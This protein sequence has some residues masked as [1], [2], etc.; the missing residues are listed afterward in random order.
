[1]SRRCDLEPRRATARTAGTTTT[2]IRGRVVSDDTGDPI[3]NARVGIADGPDAPAALTDAEGRFI[4]PVP[5]GQ[6]DLSASK[7]GYV[8]ATAPP[9]DGAEI[10]LVKGAASIGRVLDDLGEPMPVMNVVAFRRGLT[11]GHATFDRVSAAETDDLGEYRLFD[12]PSGEYVVAT[13]PGRRDVGTFS[14]PISP[15]NLVVRHYYGPADAPE[16]AR[17]INCVQTTRCRASTSRSG[18]RSSTCS[19]RQ[20]CPER[21]QVRPA[22]SGGASCAPAAG[23]RPSTIRGGN[24]GT[25]TSGR[26]GV[27]GVARRPRDACDAGGG[28]GRGRSAEA[29]PEVDPASARR[30]AGPPPV[31]LT[32]DTHVTSPMGGRSRARRM[33]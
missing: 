19:R 20:I 1:V 10:R 33:P 5:A 27:P 12:L 24:R 32:S 11:S 28:T 4:L 25:G 8:K 18:C 7:T 3:R 2:T 22:S 15:E 26:A 21:G 17:P 29:A 6:T 13:A 14:V 31:T 9:S 16:R 23:S 30:D